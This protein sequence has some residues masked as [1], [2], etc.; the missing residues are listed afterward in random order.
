M[1][2]HM[3]QG[4]EYSI[5]LVNFNCGFI[6]VLSYQVKKLVRRL[7]ISCSVNI[8]FYQ[9]SHLADWSVVLR[10]DPYFCTEKAL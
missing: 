3:V 10:V 2:D 1:F 6:V 8:F 4:K 9:S 7:E 5:Y